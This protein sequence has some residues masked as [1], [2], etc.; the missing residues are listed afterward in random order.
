MGKESRRPRKSGRICRRTRRGQSSPRLVPYL[1]VYT[2][3][4]LGYFALDMQLMHLVFLMTGKRERLRVAEF[5]N[6]RLKADPDAVL[7]DFRPL[8]DN[9]FR[10][11]DTIDDCFRDRTV[12]CS[13]SEL[14]QFLIELWESRYRPEQRRKPVFHPDL[15]QLREVFRFTD[16]DLAIITFLHC[17]NSVSP[18]ET[19]TNTPVF[20]MFMKD[21]A[22]AAGI[23]VLRVKQRLASDG[24][25]LS[26]GMV[27]SVSESASHFELR[28]DIVRFFS[29]VR[30]LSFLERYAAA[31]RGPTYPLDSFSIDPE[32]TAIAGRVLA[33]RSSSAVLL[34]GKPGTG[35]TE[36]ARALAAQAGKRA[37]FL[38][39]PGEQEQQDRRIVLRIALRSVAREGGIL[40]VDEADSLLNT[41]QSFGP[42]SEKGW[43]VSLLD[44]AGVSSIWI[45]NSIADVHEAV[46]RRFAYSL[47]FRSFTE[48]ERLRL[49]QRLLQESPL[50]AGIPDSMVR[51]LAERYEVS[52]GGI[53]ACLATL[54]ALVGKRRRP[55]ES[56]IRSTLDELLSRHIALTGGETRPPKSKADPAYRP[57]I[58]HVDGDL[59]LLTRSIRSFCRA[60]ERRDGVPLPPLN[61]LFSGPS[62]T[63]KTEFARHVAR[64]TGRRL[65]V[66][67]GSDLLSMWVGGTERNIREAFSEASESGSILFLDEADSLFLDRMHATHSWERS[68][69][70]ELLTR[71]EEHTSILICCTNLPDALDQAVLR[72]FS[73]KIT[74]RPLTADGSETLYDSWFG[75]DRPALPE[76]LRRALRAIPELTPGDFR[77]VADRFRFVEA[78]AVDHAALI[79]E[80][81]K[82]ASARSRRSSARIGFR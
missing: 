79:T 10:L 40:I 54:A 18:L 64:E 26:S 45:T 74:F 37:F 51:E 4:L 12:S 9:P 61:V 16:E 56:Y 6:S 62:G 8:A 7:T 82:E 23:P 15:E 52:S 39:Q 43:M 57:D 35:K 75:R 22:A 60:R 1:R 73:W 33:S 11:A 77:V 13:I 66:R 63:G 28:D 20:E 41:E 2:D 42:H 14:E 50:K 38:G 53:S 70:N 30:D 29:G 19:L 68:Q 3:N 21:T 67:K 46:L 71:M 76:T 27:N 78:G 32:Q 72:R 44:S 65:L 81:E 55:D 36:F 59:D 58:L 17:R 80:L 24:L 47:S 69:T 48:Q 34:Y 25:L 31:D 5:M 49:W